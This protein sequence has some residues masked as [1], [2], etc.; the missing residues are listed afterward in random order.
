[1]NCCQ[2]F[3]RLICTDKGFRSLFT[4]YMRMCVHYKS[5]TA[6]SVDVVTKLEEHRKETHTKILRAV[7]CVEPETREPCVECKSSVDC[8]KICICLMGEDLRNGDC[9][10]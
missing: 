4:G 10:R 2:Q 6:M 9:E 8:A 1:M 5:L 7:G 3:H